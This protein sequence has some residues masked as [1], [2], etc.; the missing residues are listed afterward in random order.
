MYEVGHI[1]DDNVSQPSNDDERIQETF[2]PILSR[3]VDWKQGE[4]DDEKNPIELLL[5]HDHF[6]FF[7][8]GHVDFQQGF[9]LFLVQFKQQVEPVGVPKPFGRVV[10]VQFRAEVLMVESV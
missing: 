3:G 2:S 4:K 5:E 7:Q 8:V 10:R 1:Q 9:L 6:V